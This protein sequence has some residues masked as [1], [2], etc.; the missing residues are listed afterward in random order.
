MVG[1]FDCLIDD[2]QSSFVVVVV[3]VVVVTFYFFG[4]SFDC[5]GSGSRV[6]HGGMVGGEKRSCPKTDR[7]MVPASLLLLMIPFT[8]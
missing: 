4:V 2:D 8:L 1:V 6:V 5:G 3:V 7:F